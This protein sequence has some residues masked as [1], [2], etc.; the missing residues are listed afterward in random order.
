MDERIGRI[1]SRNHPCVTNKRRALGAGVVQQIGKSA[2]CSA[3]RSA[4]A[5]DSCLSG[6]G[7]VQELCESA[8][9]AISRRRS[10]TFIRDNN[11]LTRRGGVIK[12]NSSRCFGGARVGRNKVLQHSRIVRKSSPVNLEEGRE[13]YIKHRRDRND[14]STGTFREDDVSDDSSCAP[15]T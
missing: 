6:S 2:S 1:R 13:D 11:V 7:S 5:D 10:A 15:E 9:D 3:Y 8:I 12:I 14:V 4:I